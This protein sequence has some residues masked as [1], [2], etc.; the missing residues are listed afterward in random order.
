MPAQR[1]L[2]RAHKLHFGPCLK[3]AGA[4]TR[5]D[6]RGSPGHPRASQPARGADGLIG[7]DDDAEAVRNVLT[8]AENGLVTLTR[9]SGRELE[10]APGTPTSLR[11]G[12]WQV[13]LSPDGSQLAVV[14]YREA[15][16]WDIASG[17]EVRRFT[18]HTHDVLTV[19]F[20]PDGHWVLSA[21]MDRSA[22]LWDAAT[23]LEVRRFIGHTDTVWG[24][25]FSPDGTRIATASRDGTARVWELASGRVLLQLSGHTSTTVTAVFSPDGD[26]PGNRRR[27]RSAPV[28]A[29]DRRSDSTGKKPSHAHLDARGVSTVSAFGHVPKSSYVISRDSV[30][31]EPGRRSPPPNYS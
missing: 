1:R 11:A 3:G 13:A 4:K 29:A 19:A 25:R 23:G 17:R 31:H 21:A 22:L 28:C 26:A 15:Y 18:G 7:S 9:S 6:G 8:D 30:S 24:A 16:L 20:S 10:A 12:P 14:N 27:S 2:P 5:D